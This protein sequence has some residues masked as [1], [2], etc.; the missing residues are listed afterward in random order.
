MA[1]GTLLIEEKLLR[2]FGKVGH[3]EDIVIHLDFRKYGLGKKMIQVVGQDAPGFPQSG[4]LLVA[5]FFAFFL[6]GVEQSLADN[7]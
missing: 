2:N 7:L 4:I 6:H 1:T 5:E 3:I